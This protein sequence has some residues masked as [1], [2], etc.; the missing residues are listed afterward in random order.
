MEAVLRDAEDDEA[1]AHLE[2]LKAPSA[3]PYGAGLSLG[4]ALLDPVAQGAQRLELDTSP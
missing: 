4:A 1:E 2:Q 3:L